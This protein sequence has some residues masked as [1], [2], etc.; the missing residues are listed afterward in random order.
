M[1]L[2]IV[3]GAITALIVAAMAVFVILIAV[4]AVLV[5]KLRSIIPPS[6]HARPPVR[7]RP[8]ARTPSDDCPEPPGTYS[9]EPR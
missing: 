9:V 3:T 1:M 5:R 2:H 6:P 8:A 4:N 7:A